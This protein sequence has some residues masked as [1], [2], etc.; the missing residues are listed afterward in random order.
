MDARELHMADVHDVSGRGTEK[1]YGRLFYTKGKS[2]ISDAFAT[3]ESNSR[4]PARIRR[5]RGGSPHQ[6]VS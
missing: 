5:L 3:A 4:E 2:L 6:L 1:T